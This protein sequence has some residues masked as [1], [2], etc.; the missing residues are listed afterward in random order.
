[1]K[2]LSTKE[3]Y[4]LSNE[5]IDAISQRYFDL[6]TELKYQNKNKMAIRLNIENY[7]IGYQEKF[8]ED[9]EVVLQIA[10]KIG[11]PSITLEIQGEQYNPM[12]NSDDSIGEWNNVLLQNMSVAPSITYFNNKNY[13]SLKLN[14]PAL[15]PIFKLLISL[16]VGAILGGLGFLLPDDARLTFLQGYLT[17]IY[18]AFLGLLSFVGLTLVLLSTISGIS[19]VG[20]IFTFSKIG[21][22]LANTLMSTNAVILLVI[23]IIAIGYF[24]LSFTTSTKG[25][26][27]ISE[28]F[29]IILQILPSNIIAPF[30]E[31]N[32]LQIL[33]IGFA[34]GI[35]ILT[36]GDTAKP[37]AK[38]F[39]QMF[40]V[41][42]VIMEFLEKLLPAFISVVVMQIMWSSEIK[43]VAGMWRLAVIGVVACVVVSVISV[44][45]TS[46]KNKISPALLMK[47]LLPTYLLALST[48]SSSAVHGTCVECCNSKFGIDSKLT[49]FGISFTTGVF[50]PCVGV[51]Y[52]I[53]AL[54]LAQQYAID[55]SVMWIITAFVICF[56]MSI[57]TPPVAG[58]TSV[59]YTIIFMQ[60]GIPTKILA[61]VLA[62]NVV[63]EFVVTAT[64]KL[65]ICNTLLNVANKNGL[66]DTK[67]LYKKD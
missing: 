61:V 66:V 33:V 32:A 65:L 16:L 44:A 23:G 53:T 41:S 34:I 40:S 59:A 19:E 35:A 54:Y 42:L 62:L 38:F 45:Y 55:V 22:R 37:L 48:A 31:G 58:G 36:L 25:V 26:S 5:S 2:L 50:K 9:T 15:N 10:S 52:L 29:S 24:S 4:N 60:L 18:N 57:A 67:K 14:K 28:I 6:L 30:Y 63:F 20:D 64:D 8:G 43:E 51:I 3:K 1:M 49:T 39:N 7:L 12:E 17:P 56:I 27:Q 46:I 13:I 21:K 11:K 47:K